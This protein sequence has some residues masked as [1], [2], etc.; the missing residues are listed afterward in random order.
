MFYKAYSFNQDLSQWCVSNIDSKPIDFD[1]D[2]TSWE[3]G[4]A[5]RPQ[6]GTCPRGENIVQWPIEID[7]VTYEEEDAH[8]FVAN[9]NAVNLPIPS[10]ELPIFVAVNGVDVTPTSFVTRTFE[11]P[12][13]GADG[14]TTTTSQ[15]VEVAAISADDGD[16]I[17]AIFDWENTNF[18]N[19]DW[20][21]DILQFGYN[22]D[23]GKRNQLQSGQYAFSWMK[24]NP[25]AISNLDISN[26][27]D[28]IFMFANATSFNQDLSQWDISNV[29]NIEFMFFQSAFN[30]DIS[31]WNTSQVTN[32]QNMFNGASKFNQDISN[33]NTSKVE[34]MV[35]M[36]QNAT[37]FNQDLSGWCVSLIGSAQFNFDDGATAW[38]K[39]KPVW[40]TCPRNEHIQ[41]PDGVLPEGYELED[42]H[43]FIA[44]DK[45]VQLP[46]L[47]WTTPTFLAVDGVEKNY[48]EDVYG[49]AFN[50][51]IIHA[52]FDWNNEQDARQDWF[53]DILQFGLNSK[54]GKRNQIRMG[55]LAFGNMTAN[56]AAISK[57]DVS[58]LK[59]T[60]Y[61]FLRAKSFNQDLSSWDVSNVVEMSGM[62]SEAS[63]FNSD[64]SGWDVSRVVGL[65]AEYGMSLMFES[66]SSFNQD[67][68]QWCVS[69]WVR[70]PVGFDLGTARTWTKPKPVWGTCPTREDSKDYTWPITIG[71]KT[72]QKEDAH[73]F[74]AN[75]L[76]VTFPTELAT[77]PIFVGVNGQTKDP[78]LVTRTVEVEEIGVDGVATT[79]SQEVQVASIG[80]VSKG[81]IIEAIFDWNNT[82]GQS[83]DWFSDILQFGL[84]SRTG[85]RNQLKTGYLSFY[86]MTANPAAISELDV[87][88]LFFVDEMF[89]RSSFNQ[90]ISKWDTSNMRA[91]FRMFQYASDFNQDISGWNT[92]NVMDMDYMFDAA[93]SFNQDLSQWC[94]SNI[95]SKP[96]LFDTNSG[97]EGDTAK[98]P[99]W[100]NCPRGEDFVP[101]FNDAILPDGYEIEDCHIFVANGEPVLFPVASNDPRNCPIVFAA[102]DG[103]EVTPIYQL[104]CWVTFAQPG[105]TIRAI[106]DWDNRTSIAPQNW[107]FDILQFGLNS[108]TGKRNQ[109]KSGNHA[110]AWMEEANPAVI[111]N[112]DTS[113]LTDMHYMFRIAKF[114]NQDISGWETSN[115]TDMSC[116][117]RETELFDADLSSWDVSNVTDMS[118]MFCRV[119]G[120]NQDIS[121][122]DTSKVTNMNGMFDRAKG[123]NQDISGWDTSKVKDMVNMF[124]FADPF[125]QDL[126]QWC[127]SLIKTKPSGFDSGSTDWWTKP[128]PV[129]G[130]CPR[131]EDGS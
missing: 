55:S 103:V 83:Q 45:K 34:L 115:V 59:T 35:G 74:V 28:M 72:Y 112:L 123:F 128:R 88:N 9:G 108:V 46:L 101:D 125:N 7:G 99:Q 50:G 65:S 95:D 16:I 68:S 33:W 1:K 54:T 122:W 13:I 57:L 80:T 126:S 48:Y 75:G 15:E 8:I 116:M 12:E 11:V 64:I 131:G 91:M 23:T 14:V 96:S 61:M 76:K 43:I 67:L 3:G 42:C 40:G 53:S 81:D 66:A 2:T 63:S 77:I 82:E 129:W 120:F 114:F 56:P 51:S 87:S 105:Q 106:F 19:Q 118:W 22:S 38:T 4:D 25:A 49:K 32:M 47:Q 90:D 98:H 69:H 36:F 100:G 110:F 78:I 85:K 86:K 97:F 29:T 94:V 39:P 127:V 44:N 70:K 102:V 37:S 117:F 17:H 71:D 109:L 111:S 121:K 89:T 5:T 92:S 73:I 104:G 20:F 24:A 31:G 107:F 62:F 79:T 30:K 26:L 21:S 27:T 6:W 124:T 93:T 60:V 130:T 58:N 84:N 119:K 18:L 10:G 41:L 113:N 52:I